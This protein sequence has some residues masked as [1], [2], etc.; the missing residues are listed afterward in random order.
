M[1]DEFGNPL[2]AAEIEALP[3][4]Y[5]LADEWRPTGKVHTEIH[6]ASL[7]MWCWAEYRNITT[8]AH[9][10]RPNPLSSGASNGTG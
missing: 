1:T 5:V 4:A 7:R 9:E 8:G 10:W 6:P 3:G 2:T